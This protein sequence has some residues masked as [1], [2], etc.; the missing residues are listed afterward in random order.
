[1]AARKQV[2]LTPELDVAVE[3]FRFSKRYK[4][5]SDALR[6]LIEDGLAWDRAANYI[7]D[8]WETIYTI[9]AMKDEP[10]SNGLLLDKLANDYADVNLRVYNLEEFLASHGVD[11]DKQSTADQ[12]EMNSSESTK[13]QDDPRA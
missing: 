2:S 11:S 12:V 7:N 9:Q 13:Q 4:S 8:L 3:N 10:A 6:R 1:M 5:E